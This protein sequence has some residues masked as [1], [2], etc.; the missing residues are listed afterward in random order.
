MIPYCLFLLVF[1]IQEI[2][3]ENCPN[4]YVKSS[5]LCIHLSQRNLALDKME[6][7]CMNE[8]QMGKPLLRRLTDKEMQGVGKTL[9]DFSE[10][11][12]PRE[13]FIGMQREAD[14]MGRPSKTFKYEGGY[15][16]VKQDDY[17]LWDSDPSNYDCGMVTYG[18]GFKVRPAGCSE[19]A[20]FMCEK[21]EKPCEERS[22][23]PLRYVSYYGRC[24]AIPNKEKYNDAVN[25]C[26][27]QMKGHVA[28]YKTEDE[29]NAIAEVVLN[30]QQTLDGG[31]F[32]GLRKSDDGEWEYVDGEEETTR[33]DPNDPRERDCG[34]YRFLKNVTVGIFTMSCN[35]E[36][37]VLCQYGG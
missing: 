10:N 4:L 15:G 32:A 6:G 21:D 3:C 11:Q 24:L 26:K 33:W 16:S 22:L 28:T 36:L 25:M 18:S 37:R 19:S 35:E 2:S 17:S 5:K 8:A 12:F 14:S 7:Y 1:V 27:Y 30:S 13:V 20:L 9:K 31:I 23:Y 29:S 34:V